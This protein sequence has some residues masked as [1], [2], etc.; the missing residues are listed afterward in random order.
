MDQVVDR[1]IVDVGTA[2]AAIK[3]YD[4]DPDRAPESIHYMTGVIA[5][6]DLLEALV[7]ATT[8]SGYCSARNQT[9]RMV[10]AMDIA[11]VLRDEAERR[12]DY[13]LDGPF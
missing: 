1:I 6:S 4:G 3:G 10:S 13:T 11:A 9:E 12:L 8:F 5:N 2:L 7:A